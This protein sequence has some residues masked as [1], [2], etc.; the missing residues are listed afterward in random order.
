MSLQELEAAVEQLP[1]E[2]LAEF[3]AWIQLREV[4][5]SQGQRDDAEKELVKIIR[6]GRE[7]FGGVGNGQRPRGLCVGQFTVPP[8][9]N[10]PFPKDVLQGF[11]GA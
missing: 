2:E 8:D 7:K 3:L 4:Q 10:N 9:F 5:E 11:E 1:Q 6:K